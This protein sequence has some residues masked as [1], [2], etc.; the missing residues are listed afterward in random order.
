MVPIFLVGALHRPVC[1]TLPTIHL[2]ILIGEH[3]PES[4]LIE[5]GPR[6]TSILQNI[7]GASRMLDL[8]KVKHSQEK[9]L[10]FLERIHLCRSV[11]S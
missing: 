5:F 2:G 6:F 1:L 8:A 4:Y 3:S 10:G 11:L 7:A 9:I